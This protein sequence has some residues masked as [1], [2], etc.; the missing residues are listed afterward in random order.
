MAQAGPQVGTGAGGASIPGDHAT[1]EERRTPSAPQLAL[2]KAGGA[3][4]GIGEKFST[5]PVTGTA[6]I[7]VPIITTSGRAEFSPQLSLVYDSGNGNGVF[8]LGWSVG[9]PLISRKSKKCLDF[10]NNL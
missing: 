9:V 10:L 4:R 2:P 8:G 5:N 3:I 7:S 1:D 6:S